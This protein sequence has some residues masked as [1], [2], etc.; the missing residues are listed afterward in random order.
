MSVVGAAEP[1][2]AL[3]GAPR[4][5]IRTASAPRAAAAGVPPVLA[6][7]A[8]ALLAALRYASLLTPT[9]LLR[10][11]GIVAAAAATGAALRA[12][13]DQRGS[14]PLV[15]LRAVIVLAGLWL[16]FLAA[17][18]AVWDA[19]HWGRFAHL[20]GR[21]LGDLDGHWPYDGYS[22]AS[23]TAVLLGASVALVAAAAL[24]FW[25][26]R[27]HITAR[28]AT[29]LGLLLTV[30]T[31]AAINEPGSGWQAQGVLACAA[32]WLWIAAH[33]E[34]ARPARASR[35]G[36]WV[37]LASCGALACALALGSSGPLVDYRDWNPFAGNYP[38]ATF[39]WNQQYGPLDPERPN[40]KM[41]DVRSSVPRLWRVT[42]LDR[43]NGVA[44]V[45]SPPPPQ[46]DTGELRG[47]TTTAT[48]TIAGLRSTLLLSPGQ[49]T[50][51][52][53]RGNV[54]PHLAPFT[55][56]GTVAVEGNAPALGDSYTVT[57]TV[58]DASPSL[59]RRS[60]RVYP[61][62]LLAYTE[63]E[64]PDGDVVSLPPGGAASPAAAGA[65]ERLVDHDG[66]I[67]LAPASAVAVT[68]RAAAAAPYAGVL[69]LARRLAQGAP[70]GYDI[71]TRIETYLRSGFIYS[72]NPPRSAYPI[73]DFLQRTHIGYCQQFSGA[74][75]LLLR[76]DGIPARVVAGFQ[77]GAPSGPGRFAVTARDAHEWVEVY[78]TGVGWVTFDPTP[79]AATGVAA[80]P[81]TLAADPDAV[82]GP[83][84]GAATGRSAVVR[85]RDI[86]L[87]TTPVRAAHG[88]GSVPTVLL[89]LALAL[90]AAGASFAALLLVAAG[91]RRDAV[92]ELAHALALVGFELAPSMTLTEL[93]RRLYL[94]YPPAA[95]AYAASLRAA[96][97]GRDAVSPAGSG[98]ARRAL[99]R[100]LGAR[101]G[102][103]V[104]LRLL[105]A[106]P[107]GQAASS[108]S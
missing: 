38:A 88:G 5:A 51:V 71:A 68:E 15:A 41:F 23:Q 101:Q 89:V 35:W 95:G 65:V 69:A 81:G 27:W 67:S 57:A 14:R 56:D 19:L 16:A 49:A 37:V 77:S 22:H 32:A 42:T 97:Y 60:P 8:L 79:P 11:L 96:R 91:R 33:W 74:M 7:A 18:V 78:F 54:L 82:A 2:A 83:A 53:L 98:R 1:A 20:L 87:G 73:A 90:L 63:I 25:P 66:V 55:G 80:I 58:T 50:A 13:R 107:P 52:T 17:G 40:D 48:F 100:A 29:A 36:A 45:A 104:R 102:V 59:L 30:Y 105:L 46:A 84:T 6:F 10:A 86:G 103:L 47:A 24:A 39:D 106:L 34:P 44:F 72:T 85:R 94:R 21:G 62:A 76:M 93:E 12:T 43:F 108:Q 75:A 9:P 28:T 4:G 70:T 99:R 61:S 64:L 31:A 3:P 92:S 26:G